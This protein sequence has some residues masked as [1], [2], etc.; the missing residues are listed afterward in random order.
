MK[1]L[2]LRF[3]LPAFAL[4]A[5]QLN[6]QQAASP[7]YSQ[8]INYIKVQP[9]KGAEY[10]QFLRDTSMKTAQIRANAGEIVSWTLLRS[11]MPAGQEAR[12]DYMISTFS[13]GAPRPPMDRA[14]FEAH[15]KTAGVTM[16]AD[17]FLAKRSALSTLVNTELW[18]PRVRVGAPAKGHY[19]LVNLMKVHDAA[20]QADFTSNIWRPM[21]E[22]WV[23]QGA[24]S[25][26][27]FATKVLPAGSETPYAALSADMFPTWAAA[28]A[29]RSME[30][31]FKKVHPGK[32]YQAAVDTMGKIR[33]IA[34]RELWVVVER[35]EK[36]K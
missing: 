29:S 5:A 36:K 16:T 15:L 7:T 20:A 27:L 1:A 3:A 21:A 24:M 10:E 12:A 34:R 6:G 22:E 8:T 32:N 11:V 9:G 25:G 23:K 17:Q 28:F 4:I 30:E 19:I 26:W 35:V 14:T 31:A 18:R 13:E 2:M 33:D